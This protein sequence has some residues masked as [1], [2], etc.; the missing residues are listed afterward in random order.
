MVFPPAAPHPVVPPTTQ[1][2]SDETIDE[3]A[4]SLYAGESETVFGAD[5]LL[6]K[7]DAL[8]REYEG[9]LETDNK[10]LTTAANLAP[11]WRK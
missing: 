1:P 7:A 10:T 8:G 6:G 2:P 5:D 3:A 9:Q 4:G 11:F